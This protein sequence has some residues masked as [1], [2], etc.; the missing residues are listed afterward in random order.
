MKK[1]ILALSVLVLALVLIGVLAW[2]N[3]AGVAAHCLSRELNNVPVK[4]DAL[5]F[6][7]GRTMINHLWIGNPRGSKTK[8]AFVTEKTEIDAT[9]RQMRGNPMTIDAIVM[10]DIFVGV[11][12]FRGNDTNWNHILKLNH[13]KKKSS[14][15]YVIKRLTIRNLTV[16]VTQADGSVKRYPTIDQMEFNNITSASGFP[17]D[18]IEKAIFKLVMREIFK[19]YGL[20]QLN[21]TLDAVVP[22]GSPLKYLFK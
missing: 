19:K 4:I 9:W 2:V 14:R 12:I 16:E 11:E 6:G 13:P 10:Q 17:I 3:R 22:G 1:L 15:D 18:E 21:D 7:N 5:D 20:Q 8:T